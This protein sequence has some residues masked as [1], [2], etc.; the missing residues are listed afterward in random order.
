[1]IA[2]HQNRR[3]DV[4]ALTALSPVRLYEEN[5]R[6]ILKLRNVSTDSYVPVFRI[7]RHMLYIVCV[8]IG[9]RQ[10]KKRKKTGR[11]WK[12]LVEYSTCTIQN[13]R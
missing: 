10:Q 12:V 3:T 13:S 4:L 6:R 5:P 7:M 8:F 9:K 2:N 11:R 1:M